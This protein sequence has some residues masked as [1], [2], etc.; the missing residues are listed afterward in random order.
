MTN[1]LRTVMN[2]A[3][4]GRIAETRAAAE[5]ARRAAL[6]SA[7]T[8]FDV[9]RVQGVICTVDDEE[10]RARRWSMISDLALVLGVPHGEVQL[11]LDLV[12]AEQGELAQLRSIISSG[13]SRRE[14]LARVDAVMASLPKGT[15]ERGRCTHKGRMGWKFRGVGLV[16]GTDRLYCRVCGASVV[17]PARAP[18]LSPDA[19]AAAA[20]LADAAAWYAANGE[21]ALAVYAAGGEDNWY[22]ARNA[23]WERGIA[24]RRQAA[25]AASRP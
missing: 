15:T 19:Q 1:L 18:G 11:G 2:P 8:N 12:E 3:L 25:S 9:L 5:A 4:A 7:K 21:N 6:A 16:D 17:L 22:E 10:D 24:L 20:T 14:Y 13:E 23:V